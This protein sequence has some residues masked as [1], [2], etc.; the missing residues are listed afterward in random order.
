MESDQKQS[1]DPQRHK[2]E[3]YEIV[4]IHR[5]QINEAEYNPRFITEEAR[6]KLRAA[7]DKVGLIAPITWNRRTNKI[8][9]G[10]QRL[11]ALDALNGSRNYTLRVAAVDMDEAEE[12]AANL[13]LNNTETQGE[14]DLEKL[15][16]MLKAPDLDIIAAGFDASDIYKIIGDQ[17][18]DEILDDVQARLDKLTEI[19]ERVAARADGEHS[20]HYYLVVIFRDADARIKFT[21]TLGLED[22]C[23]QDGAK[24]QALL[25]D[26]ATKPT[27]GLTDEELAE[28]LDQKDLD[29]DERAALEAEFERRMSN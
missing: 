28:R 1:Q 14:W 13:L 18:S 19:D 22:N 7:I 6:R 4:E 11:R 8:V 12:K 5:S 25:K 23:Y 3:R 26:E 24:F 16:E 10:H 2:A 17:A 27:T 9:G 21:K 20:Q 15:G 29:E